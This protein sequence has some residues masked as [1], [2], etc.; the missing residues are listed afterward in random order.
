VAFNEFSEDWKEE[1][2]LQTCNLARNC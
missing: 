2:S 1:R